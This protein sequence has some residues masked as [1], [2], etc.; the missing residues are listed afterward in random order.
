[1]PQFSLSFFLRFAPQIRGYFLAQSRVLDC[2]FDKP[3]WLVGFTR[4]EPIHQKNAFFGEIFVFDSFYSFL[5]CPL[6]DFFTQPT[7]FQLDR[8]NMNHKT[9]VCV[10]K[11]LIKHCTVYMV[12]T[13]CQGLRLNLSKS[14]SKLD[15]RSMECAVLTEK[16]R[17]RAL[18]SLQFE[19]S[20]G[21]ENCENS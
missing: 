4:K 12:Y 15:G 14:I 16:Q 5:R 19:V 13:W 7:V 11:H 17:N 2:L 21:R 8:V 6:S 1:M 20:F 9:Q 10:Q 18:T 3:Q